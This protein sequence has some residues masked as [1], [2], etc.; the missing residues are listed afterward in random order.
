MPISFST[1]PP[2]TSFTL[3][4]LTRMAHDLRAALAETKPSKRGRG[5]S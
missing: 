1:L 5:S 4:E 2:G 3:M